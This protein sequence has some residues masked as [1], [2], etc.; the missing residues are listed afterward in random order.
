MKGTSGVSTPIKL[1]YL[2][3]SSL[4]RL[5]P[6]VVMVMV[7]SVPSES[8]WVEVAVVTMVSSPPS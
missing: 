1:K 7:N 5:Q 6:A 3:A 2:A 4:R 8:S